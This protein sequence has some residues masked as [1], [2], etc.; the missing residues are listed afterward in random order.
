MCQI[1]HEVENKDQTPANLHHKHKHGKSSLDA[2]TDNAISSVLPG[3]GLC[4]FFFL[5]CVCVSLIDTVVV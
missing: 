1:G 2:E 4:A 5:M 3:L